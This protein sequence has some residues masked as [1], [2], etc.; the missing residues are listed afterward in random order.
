MKLNLDNSVYHPPVAGTTATAARGAPVVRA[1]ESS[2]GGDSVSMSGASSALHRYSADR[3]VRIEALSRAVA[4]GS[5]RI[6][7]VDIGRA[8]IRNAGG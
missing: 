5:Y 4:A 2:T 8:V 3:S 7:S 1:G 6:A